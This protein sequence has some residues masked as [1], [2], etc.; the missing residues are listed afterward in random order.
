MSKIV[1]SCSLWSALK[2]FSGRY[3]MLKINQLLNLNPLINRFMNALG[4]KVFSPRD[5]R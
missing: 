2:N 3:M 4:R 1:C 5:L